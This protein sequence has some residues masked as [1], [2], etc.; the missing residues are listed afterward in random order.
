MLVNIPA[1]PGLKSPI[2][3]VSPEQFVSLG[4]NKVPALDDNRRPDLPGL[5]Q[6]AWNE[7]VTCIGTKTPYRAKTW[8]MQKTPMLMLYTPQDMLK[9]CF[10]LSTCFN[11]LQMWQ[12]SNR[13]C[14]IHTHM[15][16]HIRLGR[17]ASILESD[18][19]WQLTPRLI[20]IVLS[21]RAQIIKS[22]CAFVL[23]LPVLGW[24]ERI[25]AHGR[26]VSQHEP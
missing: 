26:A 19:W 16:R 17:T 21:R 4:P 22:L 14:S 24:Y 12:T 1:V 18:E 23:L 11:K 9:Q 8:S 7:N 5:L 2:A 15:R 20:R 13:K 6:V 25:L 3:Y 10:G